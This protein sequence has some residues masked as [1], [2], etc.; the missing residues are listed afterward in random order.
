MNDWKWTVEKYIAEERRIRPEYVWTIVCW[1]YV[2]WNSS[3]HSDIDLHI[4]L[5]KSCTRRERWNTVVNW[6]MIEYFANPPQQHSQYFKQDYTNRRSVNA[7]M[8]KTWVIFEDKKW[9]V[10]EIKQEAI[11]RHTKQFKWIALELL[12]IKK[13]GLRDEFDNLT[14]MKK[15]NDLWVQYAY[16]H[17]LQSIL[18]YYS[19]YH[20]FPKI[21]PHKIHRFLTN[22]YDKKKYLI[23]DFP[24]ETFCSLLLEA[25]VWKSNDE[26]IELWWNLVKYV[27][28][29][30]WW[31]SI[32]WW[33]IKTDV[34]I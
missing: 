22:E 34:S 11:D 30:T 25:F 5:D 6:L 27:L 33:S 26:N 29:N 23:P 18:E 17:L 3:S 10:E 28:D 32:D 9:Y 12:E 8:F 21:Q 19:A 13:Y 20:K 7:H 24:D 4:I 14:Q 15:N 16:F 1:S 2:T 31:F